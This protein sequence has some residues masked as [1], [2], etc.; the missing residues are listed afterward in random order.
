[1]L[2]MF[3]RAGSKNPNNKVYQFWKQ[4]NHP[5]ELFNN[6]MIQQKLDYIHNNPVIAGV[7]FSAEEYVYSSAKNYAGE[8]E[9]LLEVKYLN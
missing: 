7:V 6:V 9:Y 5:I 4:D 1:M 2:W 8:K 3:R